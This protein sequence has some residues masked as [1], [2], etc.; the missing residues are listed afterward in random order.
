MKHLIV[1]SVLNTF[2]F[3]QEN[4]NIDSLGYENLLPKLNAIKPI[5]RV[6]REDFTVWEGAPAIS[7]G[8]RYKKNTR[9]KLYP[10]WRGKTDDIYVE[11]NGKFGWVGK[12]YYKKESLPNHFLKAQKVHLFEFQKKEQ[13]EKEAKRLAIKEQQDKR[14]AEEKRRAKLR[15]DRRER[16]C[17]KRFFN[18]GKREIYFA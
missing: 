4:I 16:I 8:E 15:R 11:I 12:H 13:Y 18:E 7:S 5:E 2:L 17:T 10:K 3:T 1:I 14:W 9:V 6:I